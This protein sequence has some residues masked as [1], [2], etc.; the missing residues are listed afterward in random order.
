MRP[1]LL[2]HKIRAEG[3]V[4]HTEHPGAFGE[5]GVSYTEH[6]GP[7]GGGRCFTYGTSR[8]FRR[9]GVFHI[10]NTP[11]LLARGGVSYT[12]HPGP[13]GEGRCFIYGTPGSFGEGTGFRLRNA[14]ALSVRRPPAPPLPPSPHVPSGAFPRGLPPRLPGLSRGISPSPCRVFPGDPPP[15][16][17]RGRPMGFARTKP[18]HS[19]ESAPRRSNRPVRPGLLKAFSRDLSREA[20]GK[21]MGGW[22]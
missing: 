1:I 15:E 7:F 13:F 6:P 10:R 8:A 14:P 21:G 19:P 18:Q 17:G 16:G 9:G 4:S 20:H 22:G 3:G 2:R 5:G 11:E 12:E